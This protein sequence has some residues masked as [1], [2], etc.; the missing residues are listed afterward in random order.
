[1]ARTANRCGELFYFEDGQLNLGLKKIEEIPTIEDY[2]SITLIN[3]SKNP[4][5]VIPY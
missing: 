5:T 4:F 3:Y 2:Q 1:M